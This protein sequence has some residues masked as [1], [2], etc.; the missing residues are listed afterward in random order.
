MVALL[1]SPPPCSGAAVQS[2]HRPAFPASP[3]GMACRGA[4]GYPPASSE[5]GPGVLGCSAMGMGICRLAGLLCNGDL[6]ACRA[7][8]LSSHIRQG[9]AAFLRLLEALG[10]CFSSLAAKA[11]ACTG[12]NT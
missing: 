10:S 11:A 3:L 8:R 2:S 5:L 12:P 9:Q 1:L 7:A 6:Q 4:R